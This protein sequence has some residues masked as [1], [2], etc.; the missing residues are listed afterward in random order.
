[1]NGWLLPSV[2]TLLLWGIWGF[3]PKLAAASLPPKAVFVFQAIGNLIVIAAVLVSANFRLEVNSKG[4]LFAV[5]AGLAVA[6]GTFF[7]LVALDRGKA[8]VVVPMTALYP[9]VSIL[10]SIL[11]LGER[12]TLHQALGIAFSMIALLLFSR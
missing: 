4:V 5:L 3:F 2:A 1:M 9:V 6:L 11:F 8:S 12:L 7:F 10:L